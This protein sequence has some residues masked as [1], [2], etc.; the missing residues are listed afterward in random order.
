MDEIVNLSRRNVLL[1][2]GAIGTQVRI[3]SGETPTVRQRLRELYVD[4]DAARVVAM[5]YANTLSPDL[6]SLE[7]QI[8]QRLA[9]TAADLRSISDPELRKRADTAIRDDFEHKRMIRVDGWVLSELEVSLC[10]LHLPGSG[11][12]VTAV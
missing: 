2:L 12:A 7:S 6:D 8:L 4:V 1:A 9:L 5:R 11:C 3:P 10:A